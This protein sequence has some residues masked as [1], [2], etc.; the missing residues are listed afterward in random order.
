MIL[1]KPTLVL[2]L[3]ICLTS[4]AHG[5]VIIVKSL[6]FISDTSTHIGIFTTTNVVPEAPH[7]TRL[8]QFDAYEIA[9]TRSRILKGDPQTEVRFRY[10]AEKQPMRT[11]AVTNGAEFLV[12]FT[13]TNSITTISHQVDLSRPNTGPY[14]SIAITKDFKVLRSKDPI[15]TALAARLSRTNNPTAVRTGPGWLGNGGIMVCIPHNT[16]AFP[17]LNRGS[18][19]SMIVPPDDEYRIQAH[20]LLSSKPAAGKWSAAYVLASYPD[21]NT[22]AAL[23][24]LLDDTETYTYRVSGANGAIITNVTYPGRTA[25]YLVLKRLGVDVKKPEGADPE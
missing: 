7:T 9:A 20:A 16:E 15:L 4:H 3:V 22:I 24:T 19:L 23:R 21:T 11:D 12:F 1:R 14:G 6:E 2:L 13:E 18:V 17:L 5:E 25:A 8:E 10:V